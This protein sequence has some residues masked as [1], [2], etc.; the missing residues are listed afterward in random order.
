MLVEDF[1]CER[2]EQL[3][4]RERFYIE[5]NDCLN[6]RIPGR[7]KKEYYADN[8]E[9]FNE[10]NKKYNAENSEKIKEQC[11]QYSIDNSEKISER[12][13]Q[14]WTCECCNVTI[15][16]NHKS[17]HIKAKKHIAKTE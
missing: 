3:H 17:R 2:K 15:T 10:H 13:K 5:S 8:V 14:P 7:T 11:K 9:K 16:L 6:K 4:A 1:P 12:K